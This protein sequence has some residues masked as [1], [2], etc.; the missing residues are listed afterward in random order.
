LWSARRTDFFCVPCFGLQLPFSP[1]ALPRVGSKPGQQ[2][3]AEEGF[4]LLA[5]LLELLEEELRLVAAAMRR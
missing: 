2:C 3:C 1:A 5:F 4:C